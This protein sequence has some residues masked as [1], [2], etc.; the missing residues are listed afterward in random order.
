[1]QIAIIKSER[2]QHYVYKKFERL[3]SN[4]LYNKDKVEKFLE[5]RHV[6]LTTKH[7]EN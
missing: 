5:K 4:P 7:V 6:K 2:R 1:M 3:Y